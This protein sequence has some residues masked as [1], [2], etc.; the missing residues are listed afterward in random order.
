LSAG[1]QTR[2]E[3]LDIPALMARRDKAALDFVL[4]HDPVFSAVSSKI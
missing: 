3:A 1:R 2:L 4:L